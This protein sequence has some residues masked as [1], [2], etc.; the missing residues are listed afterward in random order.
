LRFGQIALR[1]NPGGGSFGVNLSSRRGHTP[2]Q[3]ESQLVI[4]GLR[5]KLAEIGSA[6]RGTEQRLKV[7]ASH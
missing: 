4:E 6:I 2:Y 7:L 3:T 5:V 1:E